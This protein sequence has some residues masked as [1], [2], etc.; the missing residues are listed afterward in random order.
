M[1]TEKENEW[2]RHI[3][4]L[5]V[6]MGCSEKYLIEYIRSL[7][8]QKEQETCERVVKFIREHATATK[9]DVVFVRFNE[10]D[11]QKLEA[12]ALYKK[13]V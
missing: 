11:L 3:R 12:R 10:G 7:L 5:D 4:G 8:A 1:N 2:E 9:D 13:G 6:Q